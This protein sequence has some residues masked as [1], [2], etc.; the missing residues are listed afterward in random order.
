MILVAK[1]ISWISLVALIAPAILFLA[2]RMEELD[3]VKMVMLIST[4]V[5]FAS[6]AMWM[7]RKEKA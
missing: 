6:A 2:G 3:D 4:I 7:W 5:W 1:I